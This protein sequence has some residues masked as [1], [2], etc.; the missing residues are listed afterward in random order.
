MRISFIIILLL[1]LNGYGQTESN[2]H[3]K[4]SFQIDPINLTYNDQYYYGHGL[5]FSYQPTSKLFTRLT[6][7]GT[8]IPKW[9]AGRNSFFGSI[10][11]PMYNQSSLVVGRELF[12]S[13]NWF[14]RL[15]LGAR[16]LQ[17]G[18]K[19]DNQ[20]WR[21]APNSNY[22]LISGYRTFSGQLGM[23]LL[24]TSEKGNQFELQMDYLLGYTKLLAY[25]ISPT[26]ALVKE[27]IG[28]PYKQQP[29]GFN[30]STSY[31]YSIFDKSH[32]VVGTDVQWQ[33]FVY[34]SPTDPSFVP[35]GGMHLSELMV[36]AHLGWR[37]RF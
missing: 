11:T 14:F 33:P 12:S 34:Y 20:Y 32:I 15:Q 22:T 16:Y 17:N 9:D 7:Q 10:M 3:S 4:F 2:Q 13:K 24:R 8:I 21:Y 30:F 18:T 6:S 23:N 19:W 25:S 31:A 36:S 5:A 28:N 26:D 27:D 37:M 1:S 29:H 35:R